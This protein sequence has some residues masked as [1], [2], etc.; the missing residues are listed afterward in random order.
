MLLG[1]GGMPVAKHGRSLV[2]RGAELDTFDAM[3]NALASG[4]SAVVLLSGEPGI[5]KSRARRSEP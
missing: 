4:R 2:G 1:E 3:L 5:G